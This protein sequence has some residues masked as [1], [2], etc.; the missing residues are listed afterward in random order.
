MIKPSTYAAA[1]TLIARYPALESCAADTRRSAHAPA[2]AASSWSAAT[3]AP[4]QT[5]S[6]LS[7]S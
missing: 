6:I 4:L 1:D 5:R 7:A 3:A 2:R